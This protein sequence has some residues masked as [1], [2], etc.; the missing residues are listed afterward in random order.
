MHTKKIIKERDPDYEYS[1]YSEDDDVVL[2]DTEQEATRA[3]RRWIKAGANGVRGPFC[4][5]RSA[6]DKAA[7]DLLTLVE[8]MV[9]MFDGGDKPSLEERDKWLTVAEAA[10]AK[11]RP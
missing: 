9:Y 7:P 8:R 2:Y 5:P 10:L 6:L 11:V 4:H 1:L 3:K